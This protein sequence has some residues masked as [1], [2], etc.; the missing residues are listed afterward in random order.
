M[1]MP[2]LYDPVNV[3]PCTS[4]LRTRCAPASS[5]PGTN[6]NT[7]LGTP[8]SR[9]TSN[10]LCPSSDPIGLGF[11]TTVLPATSAPEDGPPDSASG[12][13]NGLI[14]AHTP[15]GRITS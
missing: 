9:Y 6:W 10:S 12:K 1:S 3:M 5:A 8:A 13:L 7:P 4:G 11:N 2:T 15:Y 14:T